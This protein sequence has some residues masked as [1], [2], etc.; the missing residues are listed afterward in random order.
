[1]IFTYSFGEILSEL[2]FISWARICIS[3]SKWKV[4]LSTL[5]CSSVYAFIVKVSCV[6]A[7]WVA[8]VVPDSLQTHG[9][10]PPGFSVHG[11][12]QARILQRV[13]MP[14]SRG[15]SSPRDW[16]SVTEVT[17][18]QKN[19]LPLSHGGSPEITSMTV[20]VEMKSEVWGEDTLASMERTRAPEEISH[21]NGI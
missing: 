3:K 1:M 7:W 12:L 17:V 19:S 8:S 2:K 18:L 20:K 9:L 13:A 16:A 11:I 21:Q 5:I 15:S 4:I 6:C 14:F 10:Y